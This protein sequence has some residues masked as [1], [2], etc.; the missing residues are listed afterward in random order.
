M[1]SKPQLNGAAQRLEV[2][3]DLPPGNEPDISL[4]ELIL[5]VWRRLWLI[6][7]V[8]VVAVVA[9]VGFTLTQTPM[10]E[11]NIKVLIGQAQSESSDNLMADV[12]GL[13]QITMTMTEAVSTRPV[14]EATIRKLG[15]SMTPGDLLARLEVEQVASTQFIEVSYKDPDP[16]R[17]QRIVNAVGD[18]FSDQVSEVSPS[19]SSITA[20]VWERAVVPSSP[21]SPDL[22][23]NV[24][25]ALVVGVMLGVGLA[26]LLEYLDD[27]WGSPEEAEQVSGVP[28]F[29]VIPVFK[30]TQGRK[31]A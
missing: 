10:Y 9:A 21:V 6:S 8:A 29:G 23:L 19:A 17:A 13:Q 4:R 12:G 28:T 22:L 20:T 14:A 31:G 26:F 5:P 15:L 3:V 27:S 7:L 11:A 1:I 16:Q 24:L 2:P 25:L 30:V 18:V